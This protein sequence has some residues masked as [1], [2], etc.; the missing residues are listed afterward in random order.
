MKQRTEFLYLSEPDTIAAGVLDAARCVEV[1]EEVFKLLSQGDYLMGGPNDN[2]HGMTL[3]FPKESPFP[4]MPLAGPDR[5]FIAMPA[6]LG[7]RFDMCGN[8]WYGSN[9]ANTSRGLPRSVLTLTLNNKDTGEP[10]CFMSANLLSAARTGA[11]PAVAAYHLSKKDAKVCTIVGCGPINRACLESII[12]KV[13]GIETVV[14]YDIFIDK[15]QAFADW[16]KEHL[17]REAKAAK[18]LESAVRAGEILSMAASKL[19]PVNV[20]NEWVQKGACILISGTMRADEELWLN[21]KIIY[22]NTKLH[23]AYD[24]DATAAGDKEAFYHRAIAGPIIELIDQGKLPPLCEGTNLGDVILKTKPGRESDDDKIVF[25]ASGMA[26]FDVAWGMEV[27]NNA[28]K[29]G[30]GQKLLL[31]EGAYQA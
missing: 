10:L 1:A 30:I 22:D 11:I 17:G 7:G 14:C 4:N 15:A 8:K 13:P 21:S 25:I 28:L 26:V 5:R 19:Q 2:N 9:A 16:V 31:W 6:Y 12:A 23:E 24:A 20:A 27:Y 29:Q 18:D 3:T